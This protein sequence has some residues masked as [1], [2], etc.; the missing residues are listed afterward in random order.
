MGPVGKEDY[1]QINFSYA[2]PDQ[3]HP[4]NTVRVGSRIRAGV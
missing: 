4:W 3:E 1:F 2:R